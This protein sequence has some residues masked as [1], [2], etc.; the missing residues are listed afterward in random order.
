MKT[1]PVVAIVGRPNVGKSTLFNTLAKKNIA[2]ID[3]LAGVT[4]DRNYVDILWDDYSFTLVDTGGFDPDVDDELALLVQEHAR[5]AVEEADII[6][7]L[8]DGKQG[9]LYNDIEIT[10]ILQKSGKPVIYAVNKVEKAVDEQ[11]SVDFYRLGVKQVVP[12]SAKNRLGIQDLMTAV[13]AYAAPGRE[14]AESEEET[15]VSIIGRPNVGK[16]SLVN[17]LVGYNKHMVSS[18]AGTTRDPVDT[19]IKYNQKA[20][21]FIDTAGIR[22]KSRMSYSL[23]KYTALQA[24]RSIN[25]SSIC[26]LMLD[27]AQGVTTQDAKLAAEIYDRK[28]ACIILINKWD[29]IEKETKTHEAYVNTVRA[30]LSFID[31]APII[32]A[33]AATGLRVRKLFDL[34]EVLGAGYS[35]R[36][37]TSEVNRGIEQIYDQNPPPRGPSHRTRIYYASQVATAPPTFKIFTNHTEA[38]QPSYLRYFERAVRERFGF[39]GLPIRIEIAARAKKEKP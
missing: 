1:K 11:N 14:S 13:C 22:K 39:E 37:A 2:I 18:I 36:V 17:K 25:R 35:R 6:I 8:M 31:F 7:F 19:I 29:L 16:S 28:R 9:L 20:I 12:I 24:L 15:I 38:F 27:A 33:S 32:T 21:R 5:L 34:I 4:R 26:I 23:E 10:R 30:G 3:D